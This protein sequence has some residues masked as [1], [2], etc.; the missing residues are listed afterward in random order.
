MIKHTYIAMY[1]NLKSIF[2]INI[3]FQVRITITSVSDCF[4]MATEHIKGQAIRNMG[5]NYPIL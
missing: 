5:R 4:E 1:F 2:L 3:Y